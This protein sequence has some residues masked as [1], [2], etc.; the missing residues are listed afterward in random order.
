MI[1]LCV[2]F[3]PCFFK[4]KKVKMVCFMLRMSYLQGV[5]SDQQPQSLLQRPLKKVFV[6][7]RSQGSS[8]VEPDPFPCFMDF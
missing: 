8:R 5:I 7:E 2:F 1:I 6:G 4:K 3:K